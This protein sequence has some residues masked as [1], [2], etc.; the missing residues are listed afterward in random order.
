MTARYYIKAYLAGIAVPTAFLLVFVAGFTIAWHIWPVPTPVER[1]I[2]FPLAVLPN[3]WGLWN[4]LRARLRRSYRVSSGLFGALFPF[5]GAPIGY[6]VSR[7]FGVEFP[8]VLMRV[9][10]VAFIIMVAVYYLLWK[11]IVQYLNDLVEVA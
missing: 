5:V 7:T 3:L 8:S 11:Y 10:P 9:F 4:V 2:V 1:F 6:F